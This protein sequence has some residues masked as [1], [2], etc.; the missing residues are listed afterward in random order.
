MSGCA[1]ENGHRRAE[2]GSPDVATHSRML[3]GALNSAWGSHE[4]VDHTGRIEP[5]PCI[6]APPRP[7]AYCPCNRLAHNSTTPSHERSDQAATA[8]HE[9]R[10]EAW[11]RPHHR[12]H[13]K[14]T[15]KKDG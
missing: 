3:A 2:D 15:Q 10:P 12:G 13:G 9:C 7:T 6:V 4:F 8:W 5:H 1:L 14:D 11:A